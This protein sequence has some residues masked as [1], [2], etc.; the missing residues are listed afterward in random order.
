MIKELLN[1]KLGPIWK[2]S[3]GLP[4]APV[5]DF[6]HGLGE[7]GTDINK[8]LRTGLPEV[9]EQG[10]NASPFNVYADQDANGWWREDT[11][12]PVTIQF[13]EEQPDSGPI[14]GTGLSS[15]G[16]AWGR[17]LRSGKDNVKGV[18]IIA[19]N[20]NEFVKD[21]PNMIGIPVW[22]FMGET[23]NTVNPPESAEAFVKAYNAKFPGKIKRTVFK[24]V[25]HSEALWNNIYRSVLSSPVLTGDP[26]LYAP[27]DQSI[28]D[29]ALD[30]IKE[31][32]IPPV[33]E[34]P[35]D[36]MKLIGDEIIATF[37]ER[38]FK[39]PGNEIT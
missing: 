27:F 32:P 12:T 11:E 28:Y 29:W 3:S 19:A 38:K 33:E 10:Y 8:V 9:L 37:G 25:G 23:D 30:I 13:I 14:F 4:K 26:V 31:Q 2:W 17:W 5:W 6:T 7:A 15:G 20:M 35:L 36:S 18:V 16:N 34:V 24:G 1:H 39:I 21:I 22:I